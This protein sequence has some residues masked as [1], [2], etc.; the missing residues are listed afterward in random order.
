MKIRNETGPNLP[1]IWLQNRLLRKKRK[2]LWNA[3]FVVPASFSSQKKG[4]CTG[5]YP[6]ATALFVKTFFQNQLKNWSALS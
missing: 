1:D 2:P 6:C 3:V 4:C 5:F